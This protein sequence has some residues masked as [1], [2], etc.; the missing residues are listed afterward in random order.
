MLGS[1]E[2]NMLS[3]HTYFTQSMATAGQVKMAGFSIF[4]LRRP[5]KVQKQT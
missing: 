2:K 4:N 1:S 5:L 3:A